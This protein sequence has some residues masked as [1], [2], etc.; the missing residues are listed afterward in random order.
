MYSP[1]KKKPKKQ[2]RKALTIQSLL[3]FSTVRL[4]LFLFFFF[5]EKTEGKINKFLQLNKHTERYSTRQAADNPNLKGINKLCNTHYSQ[6][7]WNAPRSLLTGFSVTLRHFHSC[8]IGEAPATAL[9][10]DGEEDEEDVVE[11][12]LSLATAAWEPRASDQGSKTRKESST[13]LIHLLFLW[14]LLSFSACSLHAS[15]WTAP[16]APFHPLNT[17]FPSQ[18]KSEPSPVSK[19]LQHCQT[20]PNMFQGE[21]TQLTKH[22]IL[23][24][25]VL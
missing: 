6:K 9:V 3:N 19:P 5:W 16:S 10:G 17:L 14:K 25:S 4:F 8:G 13:T 18:P 15:L 22:H 20:H 1:R 24:H 11:R 12:R 7:I 21:K 23:K 2:A